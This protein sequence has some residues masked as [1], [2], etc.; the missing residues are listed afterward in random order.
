MGMMAKSVRFVVLLGA[1]AAPAMVGCSAFGDLC[2]QQAD[3]EGGNDADVDACIAETNGQAEVAAAYDCS[4]AFDK[5]SDC[6]EASGRCSDGKFE[7]DC[8]SESAA[9]G[10]CIDAASAR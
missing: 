6:I 10:A 3:C 1:L 4:D 7:T 9:L 2:Q 8:G 5:L